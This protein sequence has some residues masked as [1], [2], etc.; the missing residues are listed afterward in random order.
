MTG[1]SGGI[2]SQC[3]SPLQGNSASTFTQKTN[4][5][6][7]PIFLVPFLRLLGLIISGFFGR[8]APA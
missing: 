3:M 2:L 6:N 1:E 7:S 8:K 5:A 4:L